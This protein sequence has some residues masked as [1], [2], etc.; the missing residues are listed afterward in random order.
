MRRIASV[1]LIALGLSAPAPV[2]AGQ[3]LHESM[4][5]CAV[6]FELLLG[7]QSFIPGQNEMIDLFVAG[8][9]EMRREAEER[10]SARYVRKTS[11]QKVETWHLRWD[12]GNWDQPA[13]RGELGE[14]V[15]YCFSLAD[16]LELKQP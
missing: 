7:E 13:N 11:A 2:N 1:S 9:K 6:L 3:P 16:H 5:E 12:A 15:E 8:A 14:W 10:S 4:V